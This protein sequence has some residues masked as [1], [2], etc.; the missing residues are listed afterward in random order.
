MK[1]QI[2]TATFINSEK[3]E[4]DGVPDVKNRYKALELTPQHKVKVIILGQDPYPSREDAMGLCF[5]VPK[6]R[7]IP[8][9][10]KNIYKTLEISGFKTPNHG[11]ITEW[12]Q[13]GALLLNSSLST[14]EGKNGSHREYW[15]PFI[16]NIINSL[17]R[18]PRVY[19]FMGKEAQKFA[20]LVTNGIK[21]NTPH[22]S[23]IIP[24]NTFVEHPH[25]KNINDLLDELGIAS[26]DWSLK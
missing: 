2:K 26:I 7:K 6:G 21:Y 1:K 25:F 20:H 13:N 23:P 18:K 24:N 4:P 16:T 11:D 5:S 12:A 10:L 15:K 19:W 8:G 9:S 14:I 3:G 22:P 17:Q